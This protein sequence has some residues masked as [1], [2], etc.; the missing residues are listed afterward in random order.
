E[1][2]SFYDEKHTEWVAEPGEF[3][4]MIGTN[5]RDIRLQKTIKMK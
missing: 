2:F 5:S 1:D 4:I 3:K